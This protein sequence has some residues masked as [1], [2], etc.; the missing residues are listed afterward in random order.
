MQTVRPTRKVLTGWGRA[1][2]ADFGGPGLPFENHR[3]SAPSGCLPVLPFSRSYFQRA[4]DGI[5]TLSDS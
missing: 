5:A 2:D 4:E 1:A 3:S